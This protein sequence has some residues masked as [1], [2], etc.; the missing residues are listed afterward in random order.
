MFSESP[1]TSKKTNIHLKK[2]KTAVKKSWYDWKRR[3]F[4]QSC[5]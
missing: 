4:F 2:F 5:Y 1:E 3:V